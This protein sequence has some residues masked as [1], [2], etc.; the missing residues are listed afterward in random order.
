MVFNKKL[1][2]GLKLWS[3][4]A[5]K[6]SEALKY[7]HKQVFDYIELYIVP[8]TYTQTIMDWRAF[9]GVYVVHCPHASHGFNLA[10][11]ELRKDNQGKFEE[12]QAFTN[13][14]GASSIIVHPGN[15]G[16]LEESIHQLK[17]IAD[18]RICIE[19]KPREGLN[20]K[21]CVGSNPQEIR[22]ILE[23]GNI[24]GFVLDFSHA[25][26]AANTFGIPIDTFIADFLVFNP[27]IFHIN[28]GSSNSL[29]D[30]HRNLGAGNFDLAK[31]VSYILSGKM[32]TL[33]TPRAD[34]NGLDDFLK[35]V[36]FL[37]AILV[38]QAGTDH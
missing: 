33:E 17:K 25:V 19:N 21:M 3:T 32:V 35:D 6:I 23:E 38:K 7:Y 28:D 5:D 30:D 13:A 18:K 36:E 10:I 9:P 26:C 12:V 2:I 24:E 1:K 37:K 34:G 27:R 31:F 16:P 4:D 14:L 15:G 8:G 22:R 20:G 29:K 11:A